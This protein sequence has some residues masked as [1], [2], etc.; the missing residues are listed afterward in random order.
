MMN[1]IE[2]ICFHENP[3]AGQAEIFGS[4]ALAR[5]LTA[6]ATSKPSCLGTNV[7]SI[8]DELIELKQRFIYG[9]TDIGPNV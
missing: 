9:K 7:Q 5:H 1:A 8:Y 6:F 4:R 2:T 3:A